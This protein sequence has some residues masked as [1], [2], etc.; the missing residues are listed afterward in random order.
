MLSNLVFCNKRPAAKTRET[1]KTV[2]IKTQSIITQDVI[3]TKRTLTKP[4]LDT[5]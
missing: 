3:H 4:S 2:V 5:L 1:E